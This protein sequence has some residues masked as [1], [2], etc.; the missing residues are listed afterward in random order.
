MTDS[1]FDEVL[2]PDQVRR[3]SGVEQ[4]GVGVGRGGD[5]HVHHPRSWL[6]TRGD[7]CG[8]A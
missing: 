6:A 5:Q 4:G 1:D 2:D 8:T 3:V 7:Y